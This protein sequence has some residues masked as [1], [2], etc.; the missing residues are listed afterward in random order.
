[1]IRYSKIDDFSINF[2]LNYWLDDLYNK[3]NVSVDRSLL[4]VI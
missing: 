3:K 2:A 4:L 1:M